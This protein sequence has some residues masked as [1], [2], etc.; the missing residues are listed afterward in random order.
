MRNLNKL[1]TG[2][3][4]T[5]FSLAVLA[6]PAHP[7]AAAEQP[8]WIG[9][10]HPFAGLDHLTI[11][12]LLAFWLRRSGANGWPAVPLMAGLTIGALFAQ[13]L[14]HGL[15]FEGMAAVPAFVL[16][17]TLGSLAIMMVAAL[18]AGWLPSRPFSRTGLDPTGRIANIRGD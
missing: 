17:Q 4:L 14:M 16:G 15:L 9:V 6:H 5:T 1:L 2:L 11:L 18:V 3:A 8:L 10:L 12:L 7:E 13:G